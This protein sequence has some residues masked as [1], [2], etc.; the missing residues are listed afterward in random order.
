MS[1]VSLRF[2]ERLVATSFALSILFVLQPSAAQDKI[3]P[4]QTSR[5]ERAPRSAPAE[6]STHTQLVNSAIA[7]FGA[8]RYVDARELMQRAHQLSP[9]ARTLRGMGLAAFQAKRYALATQDFERALAEQRHPLTAEQ[10]EEVERLQAEANALTAR[11]RLVGQ[12]PGAVIRIDGEPPRMDSGGFLVL[13]AGEHDLSLRP[14]NGRER[15]MLITAEPGTWSELDVGA[16]RVRPDKSRP[17][18]WND[19]APQPSPLAGAGLQP[20]LEPDPVADAMLRPPPPMAAA[21]PAGVSPPVRPVYTPRRAAFEASA[22]GETQKSGGSGVRTAFASAAIA[23]GAIA[24]GF[25]IWQWQIREYEVGRWNS[26][27]CLAGGNSRRENCGA[28][29]RRYENAERLMWITAGAAVVLAGTGITLL[30]IGGGE[31]KVD[32]TAI[33]CAPGALG[34]SCGGSF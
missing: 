32:E 1:A 19:D 30:V 28:H 15:T 21:A 24:T 34:M 22:T 27:A 26:A 9:S 13:E 31:D 4:T 7:A 25:S 3:E 18:P 2:Y 6:P 33:R 23:G 5:N 29:E 12:V 17:N 10:R 16:M 11:F 14:T 20:D 8:G